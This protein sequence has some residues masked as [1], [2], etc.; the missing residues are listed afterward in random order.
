MTGS[1]M[2]ASTAADARRRPE[3]RVDATPSAVVTAEMALSRLAREK[4]VA[5]ALL[6]TATS[7]AVLFTPDMVAAQAALRKSGYAPPSMNRTVRRVLMSCDGAL[8]VASGRWQGENSASGQFVTVWQRQGDGR[9]RKDVLKQWKWLATAATTDAATTD[10]ARA[11]DAAEDGPELVETS[12]A[13]CSKIPT[14]QLPAPYPVG[15]KFPKE[16]VSADRSLRW[17]VRTDPDGAQALMVELWDGVIPG[18]IDLPL[19]RKAT[20]AAS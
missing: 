14:E 12:V 16:G 10:T 7:D 1:L 11:S 20:G 19:P 18:M 6:E 5:A 9:G 2:V 13:A 3:V 8:A 4:G 17:T 15:T